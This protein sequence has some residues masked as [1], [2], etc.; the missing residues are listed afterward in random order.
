MN[1]RSFL[2]RSL[3]VSAIGFPT[4][5][6]SGVLGRDGAP[7]ANDRITLGMIGVGNMG[8]VHV[9]NFSSDANIAAIADAYLPHANERLK[10]LHDNERVAEGTNPVVYQDYR[11]ILERDDIDAV[12]IASPQH[13]HALHTIHAAQAG[14]HV[15]CEKPLTYSVW[16]GRQIVK[17]VSKY[18]IV[19]QTGSQQRSSLSTYLPLSHV[20]NGTI[21]KIKR[22]LAAN[23]ASPQENGWPGMDV[24]SGLDWDLWCG[25][26]PKPDYHIAIRTNRQQADPQPC[27]SGIRL[28]SGGD[29]TD[30]GTH[31]FDMI[32][33]GLGADASG[34]TE[35]WVEG[36][37]FVPMLSTPDNPGG[38]RGGPKSPKVFMQYP[39]DVLVE[40]AGGDR[41]GGVFI[42]ENGQIS[43]TRGRASGKNEEVDQLIRRPVENPTDE[44]YR[45]P[46][47]ARRVNHADNWLACIK[48]GTDPTAT[49]ETGHRSATVAHLANIVRWTSGITGETGQKLKWDSVNERFTNSDVANQFLRTPYRKGYE[50][51]ENV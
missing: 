24:P 7:G 25:P 13:W 39:N 23:L 9:Q 27:W 15:Y 16:E 2:K 50:V 49:A 48:D 1:R 37:P 5:I 12:V 47:H 6:P 51:P 45:G 18:N 3:A 22:V 41:S 34:P 20:R 10:W 33:C 43:V 14:K 46:E 44:I 17:A 21:G 36:D 29:I 4:I 35:V 19:L 11:R 28:Y 8:G 38:R 30:W 42:G 31:G 32:Q 40:F 26:S